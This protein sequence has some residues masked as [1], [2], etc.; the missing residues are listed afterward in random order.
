MGSIIFVKIG[1]P[2]NISILVGKN[3]LFL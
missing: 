1:I 2:R 3:I